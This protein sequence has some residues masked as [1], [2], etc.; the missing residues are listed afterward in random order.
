MNTNLVYLSLGSNMGDRL[1]YLKQAKE[2]LAETPLIKV[3]GKSSLYET[4]PIGYT[5]QECF[6]NGVLEIET[7]LKPNV[8]LNI[9]QDIEHCLGRKRIIHWGPRTVDIDILLYNNESIS[10]PE[11]II[12]HPE[13][14][15]RRFVLV[16]LM[17]LNPNLMIPHLG[18]IKELLDNCP[19]QG[20]VSPVLKPFQW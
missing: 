6:L 4:D 11:L 5:E 14:H 13:M 17:E 10:K 3:I 8:L 15:R 9:T 7:E 2:F 12:P 19:D 16:P 18:K 1:G 20:K